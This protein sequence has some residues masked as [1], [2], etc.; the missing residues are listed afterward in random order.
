MRVNPPLWPRRGNVNEFSIKLKE[1][2]GHI[3]P[4]GKWGWTHSH[5]KQRRDGAFLD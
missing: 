4:A 3:Q 2:D 5:F 1:L